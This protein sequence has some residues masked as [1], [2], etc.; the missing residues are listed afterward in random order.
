MNYPA[1]VCEIP[2]L[3]SQ[4]MVIL[5]PIADAVRVND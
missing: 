1:A 4:L 3:M 2:D 5:L